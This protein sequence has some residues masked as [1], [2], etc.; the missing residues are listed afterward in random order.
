MML[1]HS[2]Q[3]FSF[4]DYKRVRK[5]TELVERFKNTIN[6][7]KRKKVIKNIHVHH[8]LMF[9]N[10]GEQAYIPIRHVSGS[11]HLAN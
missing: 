8:M 6:G 4:I 9:C 7:L 2:I 1:Y 3:I 10:C 11:N 5:M